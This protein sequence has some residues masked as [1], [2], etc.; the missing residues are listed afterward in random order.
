MWG[1][2]SEMFWNVETRY[3]QH[4]RFCKQDT[5]NWNCLRCETVNPTQMQNVATCTKCGVHD[6][7]Y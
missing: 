7:G 4:R 1:Q 2:P 3:Y 5:Q 6:D